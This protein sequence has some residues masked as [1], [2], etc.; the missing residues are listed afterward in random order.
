MESMCQLMIRVD[1]ERDRR[2]AMRL[3]GRERNS[4]R[5]GRR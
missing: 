5:G 4:R 1:E 2:S 3:V